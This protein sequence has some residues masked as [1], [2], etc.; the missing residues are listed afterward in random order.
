MACGPAVVVHTQRDE[1]HVDPPPAPETL[2]PEGWTPRVVA[3]RREASTAAGGAVSATIRGI[4]WDY[5]WSPDGSLIAFN[6]S[7][8]EVV[9]VDARTGVIRGYERAKVR[10]DDNLQLVA[11]DHT[12]TRLVYQTFDY[13]THDTVVWDLHHDTHRTLHT[14]EGEMSEAGLVVEAGVVV[15][16]GADPESDEEQ[17]SVVG[18]DGAVS[19]RVPEGSPQFVIDEG[20]AFVQTHEG[21]TH[22]YALDGTRRWSRPGQPIAVHPHGM[23]IAIREGAQLHVVR[24]DGSVLRTL[25]LGGDPTGASWGHDALVISVRGPAVEGERRRPPPLQVVLDPTTLQLVGR[26]ALAPNH[27]PFGRQAYTSTNEGQVELRPLVPVGEDPA[28]AEARTFLEAWPEDFEPYDDRTG[29]DFEVGRLRYDPSGARIGVVRGHEFFVVSAEDLSVQ[30]HFAPDGEGES[31]IWGVVDA[32]SGAYTWARSGTEFWHADGVVDMACAQGEPATVAGLRAWVSS[33]SVCVEGQERRNA[34]EENAEED[35]HW[36]GATAQHLVRAAS[37]TGDGDKRV[38]FVDPRTGRVARSLTLPNEMTTECY[39]DDYCVLRYLPV[40][41]GGVLIDD[42]RVMFDPGRGRRPRAVRGDFDDLQNAASVGGMVAVAH[43]G[44]LSLIDARGRVARTLP[45][46]GRFAV[47]DEAGLLAYW[48]PAQSQAVVFDVGEAEETFRASL[49]EGE[50]NSMVLQGDTL[51][52]RYSDEVVLWH[53][54][55]TSQRMRLGVLDPFVIVAGGARVAVCS[56]AELTLRDALDGAV[57]ERLGSC[58]GVDHLFS[59]QGG[60]VLALHHRTRV[61]FVRLSDGARIVVGNAGGLPFAAWGERGFLPGEVASK[62]R[63]RAPGPVGTA[64]MS[65]A[66][67]HHDP[68]FLRAFFAPPPT[69]G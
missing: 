23:G 30:A 43:G 22:A 26:Y 6:T 57:L 56:G 18:W 28:A 66:A 42:M 39:D 60:H 46:N 47:D 44:G 61:T 13:T 31:S 16:A 35:R 63:W 68:D 34:Y 67:G 24:P 5:R 27:T 15:V 40:G 21:E 38:D 59:A 8:K 69:G 32:P 11:F 29:M 41:R 49:S 37:P 9:I 25:E 45:N 50:P 14:R 10:R 62:L 51:A 64:P 17:N 58:G 2:L 33:Y 55:S 53:V 7:E 52:F 20:R 12:G 36:L 4:L 54:P 65:D 3:G 48:D 1:V 19:A